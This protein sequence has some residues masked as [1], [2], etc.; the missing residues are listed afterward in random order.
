MTFE[1]SNGLGYKTKF[2]LPR[3]ERT[4]TYGANS[5]FSGKYPLKAENW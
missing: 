2:A 3:S 5:E 4:I 1:D